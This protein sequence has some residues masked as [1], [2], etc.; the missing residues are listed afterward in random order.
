MAFWAA[1]KEGE[2]YRQTSWQIAP[3]TDDLAA[4]QGSAQ[5]IWAGDLANVPP[6]V[7]QAI[8]AS[9]TPKNW[10]GFRE[11]L[12]GNEEYLD[13]LEASPIAVK[14]DDLIW[15]QQF[16]PLA[17]TLWQRLK[18]K[19]QISESLEQAIAAA[20]VAANLVDEFAIVTG[21]VE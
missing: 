14:L 12:Y 8:S 18:T 9:E 3:T 6:S 17:T 20:A 15:R 2:T 13:L 11:A 19:G 1:Y 5:L 7:I 4:A 16:S 10:E 21:Q